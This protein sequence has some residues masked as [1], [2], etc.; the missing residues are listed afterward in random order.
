MEKL[1]KN[2]LL[3]PVMAMIACFPFFIGYKTEDNISYTPFVNNPLEI[4]KSFILFFGILSFLI[5]ISKYFTSNEKA[6]KIS[7]RL[8]IFFALCVVFGKSYEDIASW[9]YI[10]SSFSA[11]IVSLLNITGFS[12]IFYCFLNILFNFIF[13]YNSILNNNKGFFGK[14][15]K[16]CDNFLSEKSLLKLWVILMAAWI[17]YIIINYPAVIHADS[18][19]MFGQYLSRHFSNHHPIVQTLVFGSFVNFFAENFDSYNLGVFLFA[20]IQFLYG[21]FIMALLFDY[22]HKKNFPSAIIFLSLIIVGIMPAFSRNATAIC[23]DSNYTLYV[24][25]MLWLI[26]KT[27]DCKTDIDKKQLYTILPLWFITIIFICFARKNGVH[28]TLLT[29]PFV[30][31]YIRKNIKFLISLTIISI[32]SF[33]IY[34]VGEQIIQNTYNIENN[35]TQESLSIPFQQTARYIR[36]FGD[37]VTIEEYNAINA[38]LDYNKISESYEPEKSDRVKET[39]KK[40]STN[41]DFIR[42]VGTWFKMFFKHP[43]V[44]IQAT[45]NTAYGYFYPDNIGYY[46]DLFY[47]TM[48][49]NDKQI[50]SPEKLGEFS[51]KIR[52]INMDSRKIPFIGI[53]SSL[54]FYTWITIFIIIFFITYKKDKKYIVYCVP[55]ILTILICIAS[56]VNNTMRYGLPFIFAAPVLFCMCFENKK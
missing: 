4:E 14:F 7:F 24:L 47:M 20:F 36:D 23:K 41:E 35:N 25:F 15:C 2:P 50:Y 44:Y 53:F 49:I 3:R 32:L 1:I 28:L 43:T 38:V 45:L 5:L 26:F 54:G 55:C 30:L 6:K 19:V 27:C 10:F 46:K 52:D 18:G 40:D 17:P 8:S 11:F 29:M 12:V 37:D 51:Y 16:W 13:T 33:G 34:F 39:F 31:I 56:P 42:Y 9:G 48:C 22:V 21:S